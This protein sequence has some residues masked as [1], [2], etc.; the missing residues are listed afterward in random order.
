MVRELIVPLLSLAIPLLIVPSTAKAVM[1][2]EFVNVPIF[3]LIV[4]FVILPS[5]KKLF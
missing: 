3:L 2:P 1:L 5:F 4:K